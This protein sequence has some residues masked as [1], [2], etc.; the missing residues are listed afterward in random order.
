[1]STRIEPYLEPWV[2]EPFATKDSEFVVSEEG[3]G[4][5]FGTQE[6]CDALVVLRAKFIEVARAIIEHTKEEEA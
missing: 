1:M 2:T 6:K 4:I 3:D 5:F